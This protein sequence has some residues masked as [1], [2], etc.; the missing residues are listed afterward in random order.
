MAYR[1]CTYPNTLYSLHHCYVGTAYHIYTKNLT[2]KNIWSHYVSLTVH[3]RSGRFLF[4][5]NINISQTTVNSIAQQRNIKNL[6]I[7]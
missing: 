6:L 3:R 1:E 7:L 2:R 5:L 4:S